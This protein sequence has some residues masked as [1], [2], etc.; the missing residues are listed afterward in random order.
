MERSERKTQP[1]KKN[2]FQTG[3]ILFL[4]EMKKP[5]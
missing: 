3:E 5:P 4:A 1:D 2:D